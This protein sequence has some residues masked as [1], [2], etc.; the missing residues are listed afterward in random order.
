M[1]LS[2]STDS[3]ACEIEFLQ[4]R[5]WASKIDPGVF[6]IGPAAG[7]CWG[8]FRRAVRL[9]PD[10]RRPGR[11]GNPACESADEDRGQCNK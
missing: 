9:A 3:G 4:I 11:K 1:L 6:G 5:R 7:R 2:H 10:F 8:R